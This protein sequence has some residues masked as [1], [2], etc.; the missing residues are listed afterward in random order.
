MAILT[1][2]SDYHTASGPAIAIGTAILSTPSFYKS[3]LQTSQQRLSEA[4]KLTTQTL[5]AAKIKYRKGTNAGFFLYLDLSPYLSEPSEDDKSGE[6][7][8]A[9]FLVQ[10]GVFLHPGEEHCEVPGWFRL[11]FASTSID[12][13]VEGLRRFVQSVFFCHCK[14]RDLLANSKFLVTD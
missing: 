8:L 10:N 7:G 9:E 11:V 1:N 14:G 5:D 4:Y 6:F 13:L 3:F 2:C 12:T